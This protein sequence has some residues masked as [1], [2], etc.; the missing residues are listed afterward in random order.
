MAN[1]TRAAAWR[2]PAFLLA[3]PMMA[4]GAGVSAQT[5]IESGWVPLNLAQATTDQPPPKAP[6]SGAAPAPPASSAEVSLNVEVVAK[7]LNEARIGIE[8]K[9]GASTYTMSQGA[10]QNLPEG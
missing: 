1:R 4:L 7:A 3:L 9:I 2:A 8:P 5:A 6:S 10:I